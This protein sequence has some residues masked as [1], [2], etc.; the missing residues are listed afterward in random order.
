MVW[1]PDYRLSAVALIAIR[2]GAIWVEFL[3][4]DPRS[5]CPLIGKRTLI[6][7]EAAACY[8]QA[9]GKKEL[10]LRPVNDEI[11]RYYREVFS[12]VLEKPRKGAS[13]YL[14]GIP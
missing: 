8:A 7:L 12:F 5:D 6:V 4:G 2:E 13:Y 9:V 10:R 1:S 14:R 3:E 11:A